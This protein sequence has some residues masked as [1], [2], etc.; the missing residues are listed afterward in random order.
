MKVLSL[1]DG[2]S[3]AQEALNELGFKVDKY[4]AS[5]IDEYAVLTTM[6]NFPNTIQVGSV[7]DLHYTRHDID[8]LI[9]GSPCQDLS[10]AK[11]NRQGLGGVR[12]GLFWEYVRMLKEVKPKFFVLE[13]VN[14]MPIAARDEITATLGVEPIMINASLVSAQTRKRLFWVG[15]LNK[16]GTYSKVDVCQPSD[17][18]ISL[19]NIIHE[20]RGEE[21]DLEKYL[22][23]GNHLDWIKDPVRLQKKYAQ[24]NGEKAITMMARQYANWNGQY[25]SLRIGE[26]GKGGQGDRIYHPAGKS[27]ALSANGGGRGAK[28]GLYLVVPEATKQGFAIAEDGDS[29]D[30]SFPNS[31]TPRGRVGKKAKNIMTSSTITVFK[32]GYVRKLTPVE[33][34]RLQSMPADYFDGVV[35]KNKPLSDNQKYKM[36][37]NAFNCEVI[38]HILK[39]L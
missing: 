37:G 3:V 23:K 14:S 27:V 15:K 13:N 12:S 20:T 28:T 22:I 19:N 26:I 4:Y 17:R 8:L 16:D 9:G 39:H 6:K 21:F 38:K 24:I 18:N 33:C 34:L 2:M 10:I 29:V 5:E 25:L 1:F 7:V 30:I 32:N 11:K 31:S 36:V 35:Y